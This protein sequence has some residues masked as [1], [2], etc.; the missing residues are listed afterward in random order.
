MA[1]CSRQAFLAEQWALGPESRLRKE[2]MTLAC[3]MDLSRVDIIV[4]AFCGLPA[5]W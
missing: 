1:W 5:H 3:Q 2:V 4:W